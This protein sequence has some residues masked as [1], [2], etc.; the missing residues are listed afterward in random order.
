MVEDDFFFEARCQ[1]GVLVE[2]CGISSFVGPGRA[3]LGT[4]RLT[5]LQSILNSSSE[6]CECSW[7]RSL[8]L[9]DSSWCKCES[10]SR[11]RLFDSLLH[12]LTKSLHCWDR[13]ACVIRQCELWVL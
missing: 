9:E 7:V 5:Y 8:G 10:G 4:E 3:M 12:Y 11:R 2:Q 1:G 13:I 6:L